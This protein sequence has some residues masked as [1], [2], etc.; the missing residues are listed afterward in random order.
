MKEISIL[1]KKSVLLLFN[2]Y[3]LFFFTE[4]VG[5]EVNTGFIISLPVICLLAID[6]LLF[7]MVLIGRIKIRTKVAIAAYGF[8][9]WSLF[10]TGF[11]HELSTYLLP[12]LGLI[13]MWLPIIVKLPISEISRQI[14]FSKWFCRG[15]TLSFIFAYQDLI[16]SLFSL[17]KT[18]EL[19]PFVVAQRT[20]IFFGLSGSVL[21]LERIN[22]LM[23]EPSYYAVYLTLGYICM[24]FLNK[25]GLVGKKKAII[26][27]LHVVSFLILTFSLSGIFIFIF[28]LLVNQIFFWKKHGFRLPIKAITSG[29]VITIV[30]AVVLSQISGFETAVKSVFN[31]ISSFSETVGFLE[32][33]NLNTSEGSRIHSVSVALD[34]LNSTDGIVGQGLGAGD[35]WLRENYS[36]LSYHFAR[37]SIFNIYA[38]VLIAVGLIGLLLYIWFIYIC[39]NLKSGLIKRLSPVYFYVWL[40]I[41][42]AMGSLLYYHYWGSFYLISTRGSKKYQTSKIF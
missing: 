5:I 4:G 3:Y 35:E 26:F 21:S 15:V 2:L 31:R 27:Q 25:Q 24:D 28:Y 29:L 32:S 40:L 41:G 11:R 34:S 33:R 10:T 42:F 22:S 1:L 17:P 37:G 16:S 30:M 19:I 18:E 8:L 7:I 38:A 36:H 14:K 6:I 9:L 23:A 12:I 20:G 39:V 13:A